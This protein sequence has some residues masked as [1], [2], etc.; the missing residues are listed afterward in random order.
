[1]LNVKQKIEIRDRWIFDLTPITSEEQVFTPI[2][3]DYVLMKSGNFNQGKI[4]F[5][6]TNGAFCVNSPYTVSGEGIVISF[7]GLRLLESRYYVQNELDIGNLTYIDGGTNTT[8]IGPS[9]LGD[10]V[11]NYVHFPANMYQTLHTHPSHRIGVI[12]K[13]KGKVE[14]D[15]DLYEVLEGETFFMRRNELH[16][17]VTEDS[18]VILYVFAPDSGTGPTD[19]INP[20]KIRTYIGQ[21]RSDSKNYLKEDSAKRIATRSSITDTSQQRSIK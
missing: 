18:E 8:A 4:S 16:N 14:L 20:L 12:I 13:G 3:T 10:P 11:V 9:R 21:Q 7:P 6:D 19:E 1:M 2:G 15:N 5:T 17:F